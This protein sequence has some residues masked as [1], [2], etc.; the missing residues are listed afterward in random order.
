ML[1]SSPQQVKNSH[2]RQYIH[3]LVMLYLMILRKEP[4]ELKKISEE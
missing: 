1:L 4:S 3:L 2:N